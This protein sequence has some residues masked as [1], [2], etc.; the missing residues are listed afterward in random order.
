MRRFLGFTCLTIGLVCALPAIAARS[1]D[2]K[3]L[4]ADGEIYVVALHDGYR[5][6]ARRVATNGDP[7]VTAFFLD[8]VVEIE[9]GGELFPAHPSI[10]PCTEELTARKLNEAYKQ[11]YSVATSEAA[12]IEPYLVANVQITYEEWLVT[13]NADGRSPRSANLQATFDRS[14]DALT[15][16]QTVS[17]ELKP[18]ANELPA[19]RAVAAMTKPLS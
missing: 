9:H 1:Y 16:P 14:L 8:R 2:A 18:P 13:M 17:R 5:D 6:A 11:A 10:Y 4:V 3:Q 7:H 19:V 12:D 15:D